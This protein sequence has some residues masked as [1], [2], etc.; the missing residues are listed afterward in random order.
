MPSVS[1]LPLLQSLQRSRFLSVTVACWRRAQSLV[2]CIR[3]KHAGALMAARTSKQFF[4][5][6][7]S[8]QKVFA[9]QLYR[10]YLNH[11]LCLANQSQ[12][13]KRAHLCW[14]VECWKMTYASSGYFWACFGDS[15]G[16]SRCLRQSGIVWIVIKLCF[17]LIGSF[18]CCVRILS[19]ALVDLANSCP[20][21][22]SV[23]FV[24]RLQCSQSDCFC[25]SEV[26]HCSRWDV[27]I[28]EELLLQEK[29]QSQQ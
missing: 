9:W 21:Y 10:T 14:F 28:Q 2:E 20:K 6:A 26:T 29:M 16:C 22:W 5:G 13:L 1:D 27:K 18:L 23:F 15:C 8:R 12:S 25:S 19:L 24:Q 4:S 17:L 3:D 11:S 7:L